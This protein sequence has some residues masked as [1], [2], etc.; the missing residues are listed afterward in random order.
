MVQNT[1]VKVLP[2]QTLLSMH[3]GT[4]SSE[5]LP[6]VML[7]LV[8]LYHIHPANHSIMN[9]AF[10]LFLTLSFHAKAYSIKPKPDELTSIMEEGLRQVISSALKEL[11][12]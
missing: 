9:G 2:L 12:T 5:V 8:L 1:I 11:C 3:F 4:S 10:N 7:I 6:T